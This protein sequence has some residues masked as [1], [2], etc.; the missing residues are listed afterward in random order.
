M[1]RKSQDAPRKPALTQP[2]PFMQRKVYE[3]S[4]LPTTLSQHFNDTPSVPEYRSQSTK[5][6]IGSRIY[7]ACFWRWIPHLRVC[8]PESLY[9]T[10][11][12]S[13]VW[14]LSHS[15]ILIHGLQGHPETTWT[16]SKTHDGSKL[17]WPQ[18]LLPKT[19]PNARILTYG[20]DSKVTHFFDGPANQNSFLGH[21]RTLIQDLIA[22]RKGHVG[23]WCIWNLAFDVI[24]S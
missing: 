5:E 21:A 24:S 2:P 16:C 15:I 11:N 9:I 23:T 1:D 19:V 10:G 17:Y 20:Y 22:I 14:P 13:R 4:D 18:T 3:L 8:N 7:G 6:S 12:W